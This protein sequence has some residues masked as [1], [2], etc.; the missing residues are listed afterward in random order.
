MTLADKG[1]QVLSENL[2]WHAREERELTQLTNMPSVKVAMK[3]HRENGA[4]MGEI[5]TGAESAPALAVRLLLRDGKTGARIL[6]AYYSDD[7]FSLL[8]G[9]RR[10]FRIETTGPVPATA[11]VAVDGWNVAGKTF[12]GVE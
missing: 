9:E 10:T 4:L 2:Y 8:P 12:T 11:E 3:F 7:F 6:P 1:G 5:S